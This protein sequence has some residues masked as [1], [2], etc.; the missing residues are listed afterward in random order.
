MSARLSNYAIVLMSYTEENKQDF[1]GALNRR[2]NSIFQCH[3][4]SYNFCTFPSF[5]ITVCDY[6]SVCHSREQRYNSKQDR[7]SLLNISR[8]QAINQKMSKIITDSDK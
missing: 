1:P 5:A 8:R 3:I 2:L 6:I 7:Y 4:N